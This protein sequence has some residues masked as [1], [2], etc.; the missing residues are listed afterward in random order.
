MTNSRARA[1]DVLGALASPWSNYI[2]AVFVVGVATGACF[3]LIRFFDPTNLAM[4]YLLATL[5]VSARGRRGPAVLAAS[6]SVLCFDYFFVPPR[7]TFQVSNIQY[8]WTFGVLILTAIV[9]STLTLRLKAEAESAREG[10]RR[11]A[12]MNA[13]TEKLVTARDEADIARISSAH[14]ADVFSCPASVL[15]PDPNGRLPLDGLSDKERGTAQWVHDSGQSAGR[16]TETLPEAQAFF[17]PL[18]GVE[19]PAGV[20]RLEALLTDRGQRQLLD[21]YAHQIGLSLEVARLAESARR[22]EAA[23]ENERLRSSLLS[24]VSHDLRT[25]LTAILGSADV[26]LER[27]DLSRNRPVQSLLQNIQSE[28]ERLSRLISNLLEAQ[29]LESGAYQ[30]VKERCPLEEVV[31]TVLERCSKI[32]LSRNVRVD[33]PEDIPLIP[34]DHLLMEQVFQNLLENAIHY[35]PQGSPLNIS[36]RAKGGEVEISVADQGPGIKESDLEA[37]FEKFYKGSA[38]SGSGLGLAICRAIV[39]VHGGRIWAENGP[40][41]GAVF[42]LTLPLV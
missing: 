7:F 38:S 40:G 2:F 36:A 21:S 17:I 29:R 42:R 18:R 32:I 9:T 8:L 20:L 37:V 6:L 41:G 24:L 10:Q 28:T 35:S 27:E 30:A 19:T 12:I 22:A 16:G 3:G 4:I 31:G 1:A 39:K 13:L 25:P 26:L 5:A 33:L 34:M 15:V 14:L 11:M 23:A